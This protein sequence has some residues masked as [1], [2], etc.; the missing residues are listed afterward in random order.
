MEP[1]PKPRR[2]WIAALFSL[3]VPGLG[4]LYDGRPRRAL[5]L[6][7]APTVLILI[8]FL[9]ELQKTF[10]GLVILLTL[11]V[12]FRLWVVWDA[13]AIARR[14]PGYV[15]RW[16]NRW[17]IY[18]GIIIL[19]FLLP[20]EEILG[21]MPMPVRSFKIPSTSMEP[22]VRQGDRITAEMRYDRSAPKR[23]ELVIYVPPREPVQR[24]C[25]II[26]LPG[27]QIEIRNK[28]VSIDGQ[29][30]SD[31]WAEHQ[32]PLVM[33]AM[34]HPRDNFGPAMIPEGSVFLLG[35]NRDYSYDSR[36]FGFVP[37]SNLKGRPLYVYWATD[38]SR[39]GTS[40]Q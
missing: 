11:V 23:G 29:P 22:A 3:I 28:V 37:I 6:Y 34:P 16:F 25:R 14:S 26:G 40:L 35:D 12:L 33:P 38:R 30:I 13:A 32:D 8:L 21:W 18:L 9:I 19:V 5:A 31:P 2:P 27:E 36:F 24:L 10:P 7:A 1:L 39:I 15:P 4:Q 20:G 17:Y